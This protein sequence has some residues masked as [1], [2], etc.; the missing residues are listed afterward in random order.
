LEAFLIPLSA[1]S[2]EALV[3]AAEALRAFLE[4]PTSPTLRD[5]AGSAATRRA[6]HDH[7]IALLANSKERATA[8]LDAFL[9]GASDPGLWV[10]RRS[11]TD[12]SRATAAGADRLESLA[13]L[14]VQGGKVD[15]PG[16]YPS[17][18]FVKLPPHPWRRRRHWFE[19][20]ETKTLADPT[21]SKPL[22]G[23]EATMPG[24]EQEWRMMPT[25]ARRAWL[26][27][28]LQAKV[29]EAM[30]LPIEHIEPARPLAELGLDSLTA[31]AIKDAVDRGLNLT[32]PM[33][34]FVDGP[35][36]ARLAELILDQT[37]GHARRDCGG[38]RTVVPPTSVP[39]EDQPMVPERPADPEPVER[40]RSALASSSQVRLWFLDQLEPGSP[41][42]NLTSAV[43]LLGELDGAAMGRAFNEVVRRHDVL[44]AK[45]ESFDGRR[46]R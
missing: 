29:A 19:A 26:V 28:F 46:F 20:A 3:Q 10:G 14:Y 27:E 45:F 38:G 43:R 6:H 9:A 1:R 36:V 17:D 23:P 25:D 33:T 18:R 5:I 31:F 12:P 22:A 16:L 40:R 8:V 24:P 2:P 39:L 41:A 13:A 37:A 15:W 34:G 7:R 11:E 30:A 42:Y 32:L 35:S 4:S 21:R 44:R